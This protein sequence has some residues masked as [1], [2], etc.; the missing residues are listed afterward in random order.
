MQVKRF[1][2]FVFLLLICVMVIGNFATVN[3][4][5]YAYSFGTNYGLFD[6][7]TSQRAKDAAMYFGLCGYTS[8]YQV[9]PT[10]TYMKGNNPKGI[11]RISSEIVSHNGH[12]NYDHHAYNYNG[13]SDAEYKT[14]VY[15][16]IDLLSSSTGYNY[17]GVN[18]PKTNFS[19]TMHAQYI[20]C[21]TGNGTVNL[22]TRTW[23][24]GAVTVIGKQRT[25]GTSSQ[26]QWLN[27]FN[28]QLA[29]G[30]SLYAAMNYA[31]SFN[32]SDN[33][34]KYNT[35]RGMTST[36]IKKSGAKSLDDIDISALEIEYGSDSV[37]TYIQVLEEYKQRKTI[38]VN[39]VISFD[40]KSKNTDYLLKYLASTIDGFDA[41]NY[42]PIVY[43]GITADNF[44][45]DFIYLINGYET[46]S[47]YSVIISDGIV[48]AIYDNTIKV[49]KFELKEVI[50][51]D[52]LMDKA[53]K[54]AAEQYSN[55]Q[56]SVVSQSGKVFYD[57]ENNEVL[58]RVK[59]VYYV[60]NE[61]YFAEVYD[62]KIK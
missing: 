46:N 44:T 6:I 47:G 16:G 55:K 51:S 8:Y 5:D 11:R 20:G 45:V 18:D 2:S 23:D 37:N 62:Y 57:I 49:G 59:T 36:V 33:N 25:V 10:V 50:F 54:E 30:A 13:R 32:Y 41:S 7:D 53:Y 39:E 48:D 15:Y 19:N 35:V 43:D 22:V 27:R 40:S 52:D 17:A 58:Y 1:K 31:N 9:I 34:V 38:P 3:A 42:L 26:T 60:N 21:Q 28:N 24:R 14:G 56:N 61:S 12:A 29:L 4:Q